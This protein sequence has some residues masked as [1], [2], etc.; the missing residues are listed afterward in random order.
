MVLVVSSDSGKREFGFLKHPISSNTPLAGQL[1]FVRDFI[2]ID[3]FNSS[4]NRFLLDE[5]TRK[6]TADGRER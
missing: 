3:S 1:H 5:M 2:N 6:S 4:G